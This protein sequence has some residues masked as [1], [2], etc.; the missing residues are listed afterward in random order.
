MCFRVVMTLNIT[1]MLSPM[2]SLRIAAY[3]QC[4]LERE[5]VCV[6]VCVRVCGWVSMLKCMRVYVHLSAERCQGAGRAC[7]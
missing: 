5:C 6:C 4:S 1:S 7:V 2:S 3:F